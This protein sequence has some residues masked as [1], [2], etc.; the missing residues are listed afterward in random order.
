[1]K[2]ILEKDD[3]EYIIQELEQQGK[4]GFDAWVEISDIHFR[5][6]YSMRDGRVEIESISCGRGDVL[7]VTDSFEKTLW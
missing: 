4:I 1:M 3:I 6:G 2:I 7:F 5:V